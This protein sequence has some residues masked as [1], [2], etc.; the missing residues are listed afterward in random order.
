MPT[1]PGIDGRGTARQ[2]RANTRKLREYERR[3]PPA[4]FAAPDDGP[5]EPVDACF[6]QAVF[7]HPGPLT[8][9]ISPKW[10]SIQSIEVVGIDIHL[11]VA[12]SSNMTISILV[13]GAT[14]VNA[15]VPAGSD[16]WWS[17]S[18]SFVDGTHRVQVQTEASDAE[19]MTLI[20][21]YRC[22][23]GV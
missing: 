21:S 11:N 15:L 17:S 16:N 3:D 12:P 14:M 18:Q 6:H 10:S 13:E 7:T 1:T 20:I 8:S 23:H 4:P 9:S 2:M 22:V 5:E 19:D